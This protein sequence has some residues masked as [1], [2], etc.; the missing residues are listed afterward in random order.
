MSH[1][2]QLVVE[3]MDRL[4]VDADFWEKWMDRLHPDERRFLV[5]GWIGQ[6][7]RPVEPTWAVGEWM[8]VA[9]NFWVKPA[10]PRFTHRGWRI[11]LEFKDF[12]VRL[13]RR[14]P[15]MYELP[16]LD[17]LGYPIAHDKEA[18]DAATEDGNYTASH[19]LAVPDSDET[20]DPFTHRKITERTRAAERDKAN[21][22]ILA[23]ED[24][25]Q[26][27]RERAERSPEFRK[28]AGRSLYRIGAE[29]DRVVKNA[30]RHAA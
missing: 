25:R 30:K 22:V 3:H 19:A 5:N 17:D 12:R 10:K 11:A 1:Y 2:G 27:I 8:E 13:M 20:M 15:A 16:E 28:L 9:T 21:A 6:I 29:L 24:V 14:V 23:A 4:Q 26:A 18:I 7:K